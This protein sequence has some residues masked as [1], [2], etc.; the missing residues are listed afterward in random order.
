MTALPNAHWMPFTAMNGFNKDPRIITG[1][2]GCYLIDS[3][4]R[5]V[6]DSL[7]GLWCPGFGHNRPEI[8]EAIPSN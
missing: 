7:S 6:F 3:N 8:T 4:R 2:E 5:R 1:A